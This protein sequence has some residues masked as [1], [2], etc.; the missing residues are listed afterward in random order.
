MS[1]NVLLLPPMDFLAREDVDGVRVSWNNVPKSKLQ[2]QRNVVP[3]TALYTPYNHKSQVTTFPESLLVSCRQ[4][5]SFISP[6]VTFDHQAQNQWRCPFCSFMNVLP[7]MADG[8]IHPMIQPQNTTVEFVTL[9]VAQYG[10]VFFYVVDTCFEGDDIEENYESLR[11]SIKDSFTLLPS[12]ALVAFISYGRN[13]MLHDFTMPHKCVVFNGNK[14]YALEDVQTFLGTNDTA[15]ASGAGLTPIAQK[16]LNNIDMVDFNLDA[17]LDLLVNNSFLHV[18]SDRPMRATG[19]AMKV[20]ALVIQA[21]LG[22]NAMAGG[23]VMC[24]TAGA[25]TYGPGKIVDVPKKEPIRSHHDIEKAKGALLPNMSSGG[26]TTKV[27]SLLW[28]EAK[29]FYNDVATISSSI[30][31]SM[32]LFIGSYDQAGLHE[33][34]VVCS[35]TGGSVVMCDSFNTTLFKQSLIRF[36]ARVEPPEGEDQENPNN[37]VDGEDEDDDKLMMAFN[38]TLECRTN[39]HLQIQGLIG[40]ATALPLRDDKYSKT[41]VSPTV[42]GEGNTNAWKLCSVNPQ[43]TYAIYLDK[44]D[45]N[46]P[47]PALLQFTFHYQHRDGKHR[48]RITTFPI[49]VINDSDGNRLLDGFD[50]EAALVAIARSQID[51]LHAPGKGFWTPSF[52]SYDSNKL[53]DKLIVDFCRQFSQ[54]RKGDPASFVIF[55]KYFDLASFV[56]HLRRSPLIRVFNSSPDET[57]YYHHVLMHEDVYNSVVMIKPTLLSY[58]VETYGQP[59]SYGNPVVDPVSVELDSTSLGS[60]KVLLLDSF[61]QILIYHGKD[62]AAWRKDGLQ[63]KPGYEY[64]GEFLQAPKVE[65]LLILA[66]RFPLPRFID[67]DEGGSQARFLI[68]RLNSS[69]SYSTNPLLGGTNEIL[70]DDASL[71]EF[72]DR[73][74]RKIVGVK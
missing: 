11:A 24:F 30:G 18:E 49:N 21:L 69:T 54:Y 33:M 60:K 25:V 45:S 61:F 27:N 9:R 52:E 14:L 72:M 4:C 73:L 67:C 56:Y 36:F 62:V 50:A 40:H 58:D 29:I 10:P 55:N 20:S 66:D 39:C 42:I 41:Y 48:L 51:S 13:V 22:K 43:S 7:A 19:C 63:N 6:F 47:G 35:K 26:T 2:H 31:I 38:S 57:S 59:D 23:H 68:A 74:K 1:T 28:S 44:L 53:L 17:I 64:F 37:N 12:E 16:Y 46:V 70:T 34:A 32:N 8:S 3:L 15:H 65:A 5:R 71:G